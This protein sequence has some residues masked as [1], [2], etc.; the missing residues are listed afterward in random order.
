MHQNEQMEKNK[1]NNRSV[2]LTRSE[3]KQS[4]GRS[5]GDLKAAETLRFNKYPLFKLV[6]EIIPLT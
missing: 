4:T 2:T 3:R 6:G 5:I 1:A